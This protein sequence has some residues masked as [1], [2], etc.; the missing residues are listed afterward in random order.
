MST[1]H[2]H[3]KE[4][5]C[6]INITAVRTVWWT[7]ALISG[8]TKALTP[9]ISPLLELLHCFRF[10]SWFILSWPD[11][12]TPPPTSL[13]CSTSVLF[14]LWPSWNVLLVFVGFFSVHVCLIRVCFLKT[15]TISEFLLWLNEIWAL[16]KCVS[17][18]K[19]LHVP[20]EF[21]FHCFCPSN[22]RQTSVSEV[23]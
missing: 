16:C 21:S 3:M 23:P 15:M 4:Q 6:G 18:N 5:Q 19:D 14:S 9:N 2:Q 17:V 8:L 22:N 13:N 7:D 11:G 20:V 1:S 12:V 10:K